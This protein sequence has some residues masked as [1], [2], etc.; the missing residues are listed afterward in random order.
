M[1]PMKIEEKKFDS[2]SEI[3]LSFTTKKNPLIKR[4]LASWKKLANPIQNNQHSA[5]SRRSAQGFRGERSEFF[6]TKEAIQARSCEEDSE[7]A[8]GEV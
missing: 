2:K 5:Q 1:F 6:G 3:G 8:N 4:Y 7:R